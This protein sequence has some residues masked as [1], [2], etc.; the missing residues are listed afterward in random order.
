VVN[1]DGGAGLEHERAEVVSRQ[2]P[3]AAHGEVLAREAPSRDGSLRAVGLVAE[4]VRQVD[5]EQP[6]DLL[7]DRGEH[8]LRRLAARHQRGHPPQR[9]LLL[10]ELAGPRLA[11]RI[12]AL[13]PVRGTRAGT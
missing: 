7:A 6:P 8:R 9:G 10:G 11:G 13:P 12:T 4:Q 3:P 1:P 5:A 2:G